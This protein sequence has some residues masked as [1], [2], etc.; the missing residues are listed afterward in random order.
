MRLGSLLLKLVLVS[1]LAGA[2]L[3]TAAMA[4]PNVVASIKPVHSLAAGV[5]E[6]VGTPALLVDGAASEH[7]YALRPSDARALSQADL[8]FWVGEGL[9]TYLTA[10]IANLAGD[11]HIVELAEI[12]GIRLLEPRTGGDWEAHDH[13]HEHDHGAAEHAHEDGHGKDRGDDHDH[14]AEGE[15]HHTDYDAHF[16]LD[17]GNAR[18]IVAAMV[19]ALSEQDQENAPIYRANGDRLA[20]RLAALDRELA[21]A[22][23]P[24]KDVPYVVFHDAYQY[25]ESRYDLAAVGSITVSPERQPGA[26]RLHEIREKISGLDV[27]CVFSEPQ[28]EPALVDTL[29]EGTAARTGELDPLG[30][31]LSNG[32][33]LYFELMRNL[34]GSLKSCLAD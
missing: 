4:E 26:Q 32:P 5:M 21:A 24:V 10:P 1:P 12:E 2:G 19:E 29:R 20:D 28:F 6:G 3:A 8:V 7:S 13:D 31:D 27:R 30:A 23:A 18:R 25:F 14:A 11:A 33:G 16:W 17:T 34:A 15:H 22:L 9:E